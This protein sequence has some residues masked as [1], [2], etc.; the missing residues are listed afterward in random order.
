[1]AKRSLCHRECAARPDAASSVAP[2]GGV[3]PSYR[4][5]LRP[6][7][8]TTIVPTTSNV[9]PS[10]PSRRSRRKLDA[11]TA[12]PGCNGAPALIGSPR[13]QGGL[14]TAHGRAQ[15]GDS[16]GHRPCPIGDA[17]AAPI[18]VRVGARRRA[19]R[20]DRLFEPSA[21][22]RRGRGSSRRLHPR[23]ELARR[24][25]GLCGRGAAAGEQP[26]RYARARPLL[27][28]GHADR[29]RG[30]EG[31]PYGAVRLHGS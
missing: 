25:C 11:L 30:L 24:E 15:S 1:L 7:L 26:P 17:D 20:R 18:G 14:G 31:P 8:G 9:P 13:A 5:S 29:G 12:G 19:R 3:R 22:C 6:C 21:G 28:L 23:R 16:S 10:P 2:V 27:H 4:G